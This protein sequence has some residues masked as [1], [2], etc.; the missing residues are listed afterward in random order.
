MKDLLSP[1]EI[2]DAVISV[3]EKKTSRTNKQMLLLGILAGLFIALGAYASNMVIHNFDSSYGMM[4]F[5][6]GAVFPVGLILVL[7]AGADLF[8]GNTLIFL[9]YLDNKVSMKS[10]LNNW[11]WVYIGNFIGSI[12]FLALVYYSGLF[13][14]SSGALGALH[15]KIAAGKT[16]LSTIEILTRGIL[17]NFV[18]CLAVWMAIGCKT[19]VGKVLASWF[20]IMAFVAG[21]FEHSI[22]NMY[23]IP[24]GIISK[25]KYSS[26]LEISSDKLSYLNLAG[27]THNI[28][29]ATIGN[30]LGGGVFIGI[31]YYIIFKSESNE[32]KS[33][34]TKESVN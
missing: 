29:V 7:V 14:A 20:P 2:T 6:Q 9:G 16:S 3:G 12:I 30:I 18:V 32:K 31:I 28:V 11:F 19:M 13:E 15:V 26:I 10:M 22:A 27:A 5:V 1:N 17:A 8:T 34:K 33:I 24:A 21:G 25:A 23:Y 4:K